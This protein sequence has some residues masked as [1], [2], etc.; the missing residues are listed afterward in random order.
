MLLALPASYSFSRPWGSVP[1]NAQ[2]TID[3]SRRKLDATFTN[4]I[5]T[6]ALMD[7][8][9]LRIKFASGERIDAAR[10]IGLGMDVFIISD[11]DYVWKI[12]HLHE[13]QHPDGRIEEHEDN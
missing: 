13:H 12:P 6:S 1:A 7:K 8:V 4:L 10:I 11:G 9:K 3:D 5:I 2:G